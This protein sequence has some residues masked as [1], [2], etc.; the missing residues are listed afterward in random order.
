M[1]PAARRY[2]AGKRNIG[3]NPFLFRFN[4]PAKTGQSGISHPAVTT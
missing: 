4:I 1:K 2:Q 3:G